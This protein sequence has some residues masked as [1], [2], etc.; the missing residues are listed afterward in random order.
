MNL[1]IEKI[2][3]FLKYL[4]CYNNRS[5]VRYLEDLETRYKYYNSDGEL[6][7]EIIDN[8]NTCYL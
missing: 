1:F 2:R 6:K 5:Y 3:K 7:E 4:C 8:D